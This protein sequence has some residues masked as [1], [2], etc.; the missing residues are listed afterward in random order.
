MNIIQFTRKKYSSKLKKNYPK[1]IFIPD[2]DFHEM[3]IGVTNDGRIVYNPYEMISKLM[4]K[5]ANKFTDPV[6]LEIDDLHLFEYCS[7]LERDKQKMWQLKYFKEPLSPIFCEDYE[8]I[9]KQLPKTILN[10]K[11]YF[12]NFIDQDL[13]ENK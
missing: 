1:S 4:Y 3:I 5:N 9:Y 8:F 7:E 2:K 6:T 12:K 11:Y 10:R 13:F